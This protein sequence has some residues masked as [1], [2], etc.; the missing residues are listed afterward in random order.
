LKIVHK[1]SDDLME[2]LKA[3]IASKKLKAG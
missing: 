3:S 1:Q 2:A